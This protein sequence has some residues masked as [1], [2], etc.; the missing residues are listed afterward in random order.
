MSEFP[1][2]NSAA[3]L[4]AANTDDVQSQNMSPSGGSYVAELGEGRFRFI[5]MPPDDTGYKVAAFDL[6]NPSSDPV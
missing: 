4:I 3:E 6:E 2:Y 5:E 1:L